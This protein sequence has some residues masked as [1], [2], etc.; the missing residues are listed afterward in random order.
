[1]CISKSTLPSC[2]LSLR[3]RA[4][5][6][7]FDILKCATSLNVMASALNGLQCPTT[8]VE[9]AAWLMLI[10][11]LRLIKLFFLPLS[12]SDSYF[13]PLLPGVRGKLSQSVLGRGSFVVFCRRETGKRV[14][15]EPLRAVYRPG[16]HDEGTLCYR[17]FTFACLPESC[18]MCHFVLI[19]YVKSC[20]FI[21]QQHFDLVTRALFKTTW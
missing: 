14:Q 9:K 8:Q 7:Y 3:G 2:L 18:Q 21:N 20:I 13:F 17:V 15:P 19:L 10:I 16:D 1:M 6:F 11:I 5:L 12:Y 4:N